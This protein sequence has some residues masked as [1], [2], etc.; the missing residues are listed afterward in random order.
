MNGKWKQRQNAKHRNEYV[1]TQGEEQK[2]KWPKG[3]ELNGKWQKCYDYNRLLISTIY[4]FK[5]YSLHNRSHLI[6]YYYLVCVY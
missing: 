4:L 5:C 2:K 6:S 1:N 3:E